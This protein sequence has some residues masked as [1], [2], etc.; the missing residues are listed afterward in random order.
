MQFEKWQADI[1]SQR[2]QKVKIL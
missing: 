2:F 1:I